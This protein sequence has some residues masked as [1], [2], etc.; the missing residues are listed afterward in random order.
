MKKYISSIMVATLLHVSTGLAMQSA[1][2][3]VIKTA[4]ASKNFCVENCSRGTDMLGS[5]IRKVPG[6]NAALDNWKY[7]LLALTVGTAAIEYGYYKYYKKH[8]PVWNKVTNNWLTNFASN[9]FARISAGLKS[10]CPCKKNKIE[11]IPASSIA[12]TS[13]LEASDEIKAGERV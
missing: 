10:F 11:N 3:F 2:E 1:K 13:K 7:S 9:I 6:G 8:S 12:E 4:I 5:T